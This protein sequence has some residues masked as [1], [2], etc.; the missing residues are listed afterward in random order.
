[1]NII[2][3]KLFATALTLSQV[4]TR[5][6]AVKTQFD[7]VAD[8]GQVVQILRD[9]CAH[10]R[11]AFDIEDINLDELIS[12]AMEDPSAIAGASAPKLLHGLDIGELNTS[13]RQFCKGENPAN[14][15]FDAAE[16][17]AFYNKA[18]A[19]LPSAQDLKDRKLPG[20]S[21]ILDG[22]GKRYAEAFEAN[23]RRLSVP[24]SDVPVMVQ[25]AFVAAEDKR[26]ETHKGIDERGVIR[27]FIGN[28]ASPGRPA[29]GS[30]ITQQVVKNLSV[31]DDVTYERK[32]REMIVASRLERILGNRRS[33]NSTSTGSI[34]AAAPTG[35]RW[36]R[37]AISGN[38]WGS[39][40]CRRR[41]CWAACRRG[42]TSTIRTSIPTAPRSGAPMCWRG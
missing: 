13:Y 25:K 16:V 23:G 1:M 5:P 42:R 27:A 7:P 19:D 11:K 33:S 41:H 37:G 30:T 35:S 32:I 24:I 34:S 3:I 40:P 39:S 38:R 14:S 36:P 6:D 22:A 31:G 18:V 21:L 2:L 20:A 28:L 8:K 15:P 10:M 12:T 17:I 29:G 26:F 9:G 4:T